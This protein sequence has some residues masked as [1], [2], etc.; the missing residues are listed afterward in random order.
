MRRYLGIFLM[1]ATLGLPVATFA[2]DQPGRYYDNGRRDYHEWNPREEQ[3]YRHWLQM[4]HRKY[5]DW[6]RA[7][8]SDQQNYWRWRHQHPEN[9]WRM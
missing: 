2:A 5:R 6:S 8:R 7:R 9:D 4:N 1:T 3:A